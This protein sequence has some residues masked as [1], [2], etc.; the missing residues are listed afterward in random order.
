MRRVLYQHSRRRKCIHSAR[1]HRND[2]V[3]GLDDITVS[4]D[5]KSVVLVYDRQH[6]LQLAKVLVGSPQ[7]CKL[8]GRSDQL[9]LMLFQLLLKPIKKAESIR[10]SSGKADKDGFLEDPADLVRLV[11][12][13]GRTK[14]HLTVAAEG[15][16]AVPS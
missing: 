9:A 8:N 3:V 1:A 14:S 7:F 2:A 6:G 5:N 13:N 12:H 4:R 10:R 11:F 16:P 15:R